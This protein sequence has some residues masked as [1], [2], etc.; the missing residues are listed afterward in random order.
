MSVYVITASTLLGGTAWTGTAPGDP[1]NQTVSGTISSSVDISAMISEVSLTVNADIVE[2]NNM[3]A[4]GWRIKKT[5][6]KAGQ[7]QI[8]FNQ[9]FAASQVDAYF[10]LGGTWGFASSS[11]LYFDL[12]ATAASRGSTNPSYV[13]QWLNAGYT[14]ISGAV[15]AGATVP[16]NF[17]TTGQIARLT[18]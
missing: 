17:E 16:F 9:D 15:G 3:A 12:K 1:G 2:F 8:V 14:P 7:G 6:L 10:G 18:S 11:T 4:A 5:G 13:C